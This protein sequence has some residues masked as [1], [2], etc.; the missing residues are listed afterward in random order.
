MMICQKIPSFYASFLI[1]VEL[2]YLQE[3]FNFSLFY[4]LLCCLLL[5][6]VGGTQAKIYTF[7]HLVSICHIIA[8]LDVGRKI[9]NNN[10]VAGYLFYRLFVYIKMFLNSTLCKNSF[11]LSIPCMSANTIHLL[12]YQKLIRSLV[13]TMSVCGSD[14]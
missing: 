12:K 1:Y 14:Y 8:C 2:V 5:L 3:S 4:L 11:Y 9:S 10:N 13:C 7:L 6:I